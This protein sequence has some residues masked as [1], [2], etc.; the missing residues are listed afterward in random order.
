MIRKVKSYPIFQ[1]SAHCGLCAF[2][3]KDEM[4]KITN[5]GTNPR[6]QGIAVDHYV[7]RKMVIKHLTNEFYDIDREEFA[8]RY[9][10]IFAAVLIKATEG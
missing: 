10:A 5:S 7:T 2:I 9:R 4:Y 3:S 8:R 1:S 6:C